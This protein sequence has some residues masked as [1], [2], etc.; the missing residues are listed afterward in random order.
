MSTGG[1]TSTLGAWRFEVALPEAIAEARNEVLDLVLRIADEGVVAPL[2]KSRHAVTYNPHFRVSLSQPGDLF[3]KVLNRATGI[4]RIKHLRC[5]SVAVHVKRISRRL[6]DAGFN[7]PPLWVLGFNRQ[8][9]REMIVSP[10]VEGL[11]PLQTLARFGGDLPNKRR[12]LRDL[13]AEIGRLHRAG[14]VHGDLTP[15]NIFIQA[16]Q[17]TRFIFLDHERTRS[18]YGLGRTRRNLRNLIQLGRF[19]LPGL[20]KSDRLRVMFAY[21]DAIGCPDR[22]ALARRTLKMLAVRLQRDGGA[23]VIAPLGAVKL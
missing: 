10:R 2:R 14:L 8:D 23:Q 6:A 7:A 4:D 1:E 19:N 20:T 3:V 9:G 18:N 17:P 13:G 15:F 16:H 21:A 11:G 12:I 5:D 22:R